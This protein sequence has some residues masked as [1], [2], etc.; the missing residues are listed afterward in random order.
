MLLQIFNSCFSSRSM[1]TRR[2]WRQ[3]LRRYC[4]RSLTFSTLIV[5]K[6]TRFVS[7]KC[8]LFSL[9]AFCIYPS[10]L[11]R[12]LIYIFNWTFTCCTHHFTMH[13]SVL[14]CI[15]ICF[16]FPFFFPCCLVAKWV[17]FFFT[18]NSLIMVVSYDNQCVKLIS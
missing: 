17:W 15:V 3:S 13:V 14:R 12:L 1:R 18:A 2:N 4:E 10:V 7:R 8:L 5:Q 11:F 9:S 6:K 16:C